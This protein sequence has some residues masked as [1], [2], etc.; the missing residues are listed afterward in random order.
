[1]SIKLFNEGTAYKEKTL[2]N[3]D[4]LTKQ[5]TT[6]LVK[7]QENALSADMASTRR[8]T[9]GEKEGAG[10]HVG[11]SYHFCKIGK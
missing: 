11:T 1:M 3:Q 2:S 5:A 7:E 9:E 4:T 8:S 10:Q 6:Q